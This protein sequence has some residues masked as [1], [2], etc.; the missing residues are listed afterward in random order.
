MGVPDPSITLAYGD[1]H[2][3]IDAWPFKKDGEE[4]VGEKEIGRLNMEGVD[5][6]IDK[7]F[8]AD[9]IGE[10]LLSLL[11]QQAVNVSKALLRDLVKFAAL[12][13]LMNMKGVAAKI[14]NS[15]LCREVDED[16]VKEEAEKTV[17]ERQGKP[18]ETAGVTKAA[19]TVVE[20]AASFVATTASSGKDLLAFTGF[21]GLGL[22]FGA[23]ASLAPNLLPLLDPSK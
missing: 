20:G 11:A 18:G 21:L 23:G 19:F 6:T 2:L 14:L 22:L 5:L 7:G 3:Y 4:K 13:G 12:I 10:A 16:N 17:S 8:T 1:G 15:L 9:S